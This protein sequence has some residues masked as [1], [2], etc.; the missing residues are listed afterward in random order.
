M[1]FPI[2]KTWK[3]VNEKIELWLEVAI[4]NL[5]NF[6]VAILVV[7]LSVLFAKV[8]RNM[9]SRII[10]KGSSNRALTQL[11]ERVIYFAIILLGLFVALE[12]LHL[13]KTVTSLLA[14]AGV[15]GLALGFA[16]QDIAANFVSGVLIAAK[17]PYKIGDFV[18]V[19]GMMGEV[20]SVDLRTTSLVTFQGIEIFVPNKY[21]F[22]KP[23][24]N[25][26]TTPKRRLD[27]TIGVSYGDDLEKVEKI[28][29][30]AVESIKGRLESKP[31]ELF[32]TEFGGSSI[33]F[34]LRIWIK[35]PDDNNFFKSRHE[36]IMRIKKAFDENDI[37]IPF[38]IRTLDFGIKGGESLIRPLEK[39]LQQQSSQDQI[40]P[41]KNE[42]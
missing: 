26:T 14:S 10:S 9:V 35:Y 36:A 29:K 5:P 18:E 2:E 21:M 13:D 28:A 38:P 40:S 22:T 1:N 31:V 42:T 39:V 15:I 19:D 27:L 3:L 6:V 8:I 17:Q 41:K 4:K 33:N 7:L 30:D 34:D 20:Q 37:A 11:A 16:F 25:Y 12:L 32:Y 24:M 23:L